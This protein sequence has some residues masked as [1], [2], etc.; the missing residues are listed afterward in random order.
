[1][2]QHP[3]FTTTGTGEYQQVVILSGDRFTLGIVEGINNG[4][5]IHGVLPLI[6]RSKRRQKYIIPEERFGSSPFQSLRFP[7]PDQLGGGT[8]AGSE[9]PRDRLGLHKLEQTLGTAFAADARGFHAAER[10]FRSGA[11]AGVPAHVT[12]A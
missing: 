11:S 4:G 12:K 9:P 1:M 5:D 6:A 3:G 7:P 2:N 10:R 8:N